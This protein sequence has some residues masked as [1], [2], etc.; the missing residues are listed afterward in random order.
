MLK[1]RQLYVIHYIAYNLKEVACHVIVEE[2]RL[3]IKLCIHR[4]SISFLYR[5]FYKLL[6]IQD[7]SRQVTSIKYDDKIDRSECNRRLSKFR[8]ETET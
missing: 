2:Y 6:S 8:A 4:E 5:R 1:I 3:Q 7:I